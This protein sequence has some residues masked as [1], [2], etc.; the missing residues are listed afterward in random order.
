MIEERFAFGDS[1][2]HRADPRSRVAAATLLSF[3]L[4]I[5]NE[6][7]TL[8][9]GL[10]FSLILVLLTRLN[11]KEII[12]QVFVIWSFLLFLWIILPWTYNGEEIFRIA[13]LG[14]TKEGLLLCGKISIKSNA[15]LLVF[16][17]LVATMEFSTLGYALNFFRLPGKMVHLLL[18]TY[19]Y[20]FVIEQEYRR[21][22]RAAK[23]RSFQPGTNLHT[24][25]TYAY[26]VGMLFVRASARADR[27][28]KAMKCRGF[29]GRFYC[30]KEFCFSRSDQI[31]TLCVFTGI[32]VLIGMEVAA[33]L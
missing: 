6:F 1:V 21:L 2:L 24:Y 32:A 27:V 8:W 29:H 31:W 23:I 30:L 9:T 19:R 4:A 15:I 13:G 22:V 33:K 16:I 14:L 5:A 28:Y 18:L 17:A 12:K 11:L 3:V 25:K 26:L 10:G 7:S 20:V